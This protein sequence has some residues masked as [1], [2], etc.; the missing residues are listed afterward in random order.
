MKSYLQ[1]F[2]LI[3][4]CCLIQCISFGQED[5]NKVYAVIFID[6]Q[7]KLSKQAGATIDSIASAMKIQP[8]WNYAISCC[9]ACR[10]SAMNWDRVNT[11]VNKLVTKYGIAAERLVFSY[12]DLEKCNE[13]RFRYTDEKVSTDAPPHPNLRKKVNET[14][15]TPTPPSSSF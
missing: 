13:V 7:I 8:T 4:G 5:V 6:N 9:D 2:V 10:K 3:V 15:C 11:I 1:F 14:P 12:H